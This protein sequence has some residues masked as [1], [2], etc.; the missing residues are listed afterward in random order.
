[1]L[2]PEREG[3]LLLDLNTTLDRMEE[4]II[5]RVLA[6][7]NMNQSAAARRLASAAARYGGK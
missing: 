5:R 1:M 3:G 2:L 6:D 4:Q 7:E